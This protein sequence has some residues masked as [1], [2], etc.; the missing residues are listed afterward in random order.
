MYPWPWW[1]IME[2]LLMSPDSGSRRVGA[3][4]GEQAQSRCYPSGGCR[5]N[6]IVRCDII[7]AVVAVGCRRNRLLDYFE[8]PVLVEAS[9]VWSSE[10][11]NVSSN[12]L[13][14][15]P[16]GHFCSITPLK[17]SSKTGHCFRARWSLDKQRPCLLFPSVALRKAKDC[18]RQH[19]A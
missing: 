11:G 14:L 17:L 1:V 7:Y 16:R 5:G 12:C 8:L 10:F 9:L 19:A 15:F 2:V 4:E 6:G 3:G 13:T 18:R